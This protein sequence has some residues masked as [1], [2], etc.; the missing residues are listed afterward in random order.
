MGWD[1]GRVCATARRG[2][3][4]L[5]AILAL[6]CLSSAKAQSDFKAEIVPTISH[7]GIIGSLAF[8]ADGSHLVSGDWNG[9]VKVWDTRTRQLLRTFEK[10]LYGVNAVAFSPS[11]KEIVVGGKDYWG[12]KLI[13]AA[14]G[15]TIQSFKGTEG[16]IL[17]VA[18]SPDGKRL[19]SGD[20]KNR[21]KIWDVASGALLFDLGGHSESVYSVAF[22]ADGTQLLTAGFDKSIRVWDVATGKAV[23]SLTGPPV[24]QYIKKLSGHGPDRD[25]DIFRSIAVSPDGKWAVSGSWGHVRNVKLWDIANAKLLREVEGQPQSVIGVGFSA[26]G[27]RLFAAGEYGKIVIWDATTG[28]VTR[29]LEPR[30]EGSPLYA[31]A[32]S[33]KGDVLATGIG[34]HLWESGPDLWDLKSGALLGGFG[35]GLHKGLAVAFTPDG[36]RLA[37]AADNGAA[38]WDTSSGRLVRDFGNHER[39]VSA[40]A[41]SPDGGTVL[42][43]ARDNLVKLWDVASGTLLKTFAGHTDW[44]ERVALSPD[45]RY[46]AS[47]SSDALIKVW[48]VQTGNELQTLRGHVAFITALAFS[49]GGST[50]VS[51][52]WDGSVIVWDLAAGR[53]RFELKTESRSHYNQKQNDMEQSRRAI[54]WAGF[55]DDGRRI[56]AVTHDG[57]V[58]AWDAQTGMEILQRPAITGYVTPLIM[59]HDGRQVL[60]DG[61]PG[62]IT[63][64]DAATGEELRQLLGQDPGGGLAMSTPG[65]DRRLASIG[66]DRI[67]RIWDV[68]SGALR[69][70]LFNGQNDEWI[71]LTPQGFFSASS[72]GAGSLLSI[73]RGLEATSV[74]QTWQSLFAPDLVRESLAGDPDG[75]VKQAA[76]VMNLDKVVD[77][78]P[79]P[80]VEITSHQPGSKSNEDLVSVSARIK[81][82]GKGIGRIEWRLNGITA[83]VANAP[84]DVREYQLRQALPLDPG[85]NEIE[86]VAYNSRNLL[87]SL[88]AKTTIAYTGPAD[89]VKPKLYVLAVGINA[90]HDQG[91]TPPAAKRPNIFP[92]WNSPLAIEGF[93]GGTEKGCRRDVCR[94]TGQNGA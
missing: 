35:A 76:E 86:L 4:A 7:A 71:A 41:I 88:P 80:L 54:A 30:A 15:R 52:S 84:A 53:A 9:L 64:S 62:S 31:V 85:Q 94:C 59:S 93:C 2:A 56:V 51:G 58:S 25:E 3:L 33:P 13:E 75:E 43:G 92:R 66:N 19:A 42:T 79:A 38:V 65:N 36:T 21:A 55:S 28:K 24:W 44:V 5:V 37:C 18:F 39:E 57:A 16:E 60:W 20:G 78:G 26:D 90:Y 40:V 27:T 91:W 49:A 48:D 6:P 23:R 22:S 34:Q 67:I 47:G 72:P 83:A 82:R 70:S 32:M 14:S 89:I 50:L 77:S 46:A 45:G 10:N 81:D 87:A 11:G 17:S 68:K 69:L 61:K 29:T 8:D 12:F 74:G 1:V 63:A 73:V